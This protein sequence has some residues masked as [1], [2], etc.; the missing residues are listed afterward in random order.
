MNRPVHACLAT[1]VA[2]RSARADGQC[3]GA[4]RAETPG[5]GTTT[6]RMYRSLVLL[7]CVVVG[8]VSGCGDSDPPPRPTPTATATASVSPTPTPPPSA[9]ATAI[10][11]P[12]ARATAVATMTR[13]R[14]P[15]ATPTLD[16]TLPAAL[17]N[18]RDGRNPLNN[19]ADVRP[20]D[21]CADELRA[22]AA[23]LVIRI[24]PRGP[25]TA[26]GSLAFTA[27]ACVYLPPGYLDSGLAYPVLY[28]LHGGGGDQADWVAQGGVQAIM[29]EAVAADPANA[30]I[31]V[32]P[33][34]TDGQWYDSF[35]GSSQVQHYVLHFLVPYVERHFRTIATRAG[36][37]IDGLS[38]GGY[39]AMH[40]AAKAPDR[41]VVAG[42]M[43][44]NLAGLSFAGLQGGAAPAYALGSVPYYLAENLDRLDLTIDIG[45]ECR[46]DRD[47]DNCLAWQFE[48]L[49]A[50]ANRQF[51]ERLRAIRTAA[52]GVVEYREGEGAHAWRWWSRWLR[53][54]HLPFLLARLADPRPVTAPPLPDPTPPSPFRYR[55]IAPAFDVWGYHVAVERGVREFL[56]LRAV[57]ADGLIVQGSGRVTITAPGYAAGAAYVVS[58]AGLEPQRLVADAAGRLR[59][60]VD[61]GPSHVFEQFTPAANA[62]EAAGGYWT[63]RSIV[64]ERAR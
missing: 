42:A 18:G 21:A 45:T 33:D 3:A 56:D 23:S 1:I 31:V 59:F 11:S 28:L 52:D 26:D 14:T 46:G 55:S 12:T 24:L 20:V 22:T 2:P 25:L 58:G 30:A 7:L 35:D 19:P 8:A 62:A 39:G 44:A 63:V 50:P 15:T 61:L 49:F 16:D 13:T 29:D 53:E 57:T 38:N 17:D 37:A 54:R 60:R 6:T 41:F 43:S 40:L 5:R 4:A 51:D 9:T 34:G 36:R 48:Q 47:I 10:A 64:I 32:M 27:G